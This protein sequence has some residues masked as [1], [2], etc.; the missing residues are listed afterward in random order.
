MTT[1]PSLAPAPPLPPLPP[2]QAPTAAEQRFVLTGVDWRT[3]R[4]IADALRERHVRLTFDGEN[5]ELMTV[6]RLHASIS[7][8]LGRFIV[9]LTEELGMPISSGGNLTCERE[10]VARALQPDECFYLQNEPLVRQKDH[11]DFATDPPPDLAVEI[12]ISRSSLDRL[13]VYAVLRIPEVW[14]FDGATLTVYQRNAEGQYTVV[15]RSQYFPWLPLGE[16]AGWLR[17]RT[18]MDENSLVRAFRAWVRDLLAQRG[19]SP[20]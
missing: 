3:Y 7:R 9:V 15:E 20:G 11:L 6:S 4:V 16:L 8:L 19:S 13:G 18:E 14:R 5:L 1:A 12:D 10:D 2:S 17:R